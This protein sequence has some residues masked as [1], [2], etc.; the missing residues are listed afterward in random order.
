[1]DNINIDLEKITDID[2]LK[3]IWTFLSRAQ[4]KGCF[5]IDEA[6]IIKNVYQKISKTVL[7]S[8]NTKKNINV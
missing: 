4:S 8:N 3:I 1:M 6:V 7:S 2:G 5:T